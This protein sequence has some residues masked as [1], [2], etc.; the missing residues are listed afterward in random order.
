MQTAALIVA[1]GMSSRMGDFKPMLSI[2]SISIAQRVVA[3]FRQAGIR[4]IVMVTGFNAVTLERHLSGSGV[5]FLRNDAYETTQMF[6]SVKIGLD[7][8]RGKCGA[9][10]FPPVDIPLFTAST[11]RTLLDSGAALACPS[12][13]GQ[14]GHP[15]LI[16]AELF[17]GILADSGEG[18]LKGAVERCGTPMRQ[19]PVDDP[20]TLHDADTPAD[21][22]ALVDYHN[23]Q[24]VRPV[25][26]VSLNKEKPFFDEKIAMLLTLVD[27]TK[28]VRAAGQR[29]QLSYSSC[30]NIIRTLESQ[31]GCTLIERT[32]GGAGGSQ[33]RLT[34]RGQLLLSRFAEYE[35]RIRADAEALYPEYFGG[36]FE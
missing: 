24:L 34:E 25:V 26:S 35:R 31:L 30:W 21:F 3:T 29:M 4:K 36:L 2:G 12:C 32:Q 1:A 10:L 22:S 19:I 5:I 20:G 33:S 15:I 27:E 14:T 9:V 6:D 17:D 16:N 23:S 28:S 18:G 11:V 7:Y 13:Q 8:L